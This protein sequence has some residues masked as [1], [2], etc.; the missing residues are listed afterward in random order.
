MLSIRVSGREFSMRNHY[1][2]IVA[3]LIGVCIAANCGAAVS[4]YNFT[5]G[6]TAV[7]TAVDLTFGTFQRQNVTADTQNGKFRSIAWNTG[8]SVDTAEYVQFSITV[9]AGK[10]L[11]LSSLSVAINS[12]RATGNNNGGPNDL[13]ISVFA[14]LLPIGTGNNNVALASQTWTAL[15]G[16]SQTLNWDLP[17]QTTTSSFTVRFYGWNAE[18]AS[19][20]LSFDN[21]AITTTVTPVPEPITVA[22][23]GFSLLFVTA[24]CCRRRFQSRQHAG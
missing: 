9:G 10:Q 24:E 17:D 18:N 21:V 8:T 14:G 16:T 6:E 11:T 7:P 13:R 5:G 12:V 20:R 2:R 19:G 4:T 15:Q 3:A 1:N 22:T 23:A